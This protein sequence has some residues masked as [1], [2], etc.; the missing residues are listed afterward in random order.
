MLPLLTLEVILYKMKNLR[1]YNVSIPINF[2]Q[3]RLIN[4]CAR[5]N[6]AKITESQKPVVFFYV[7]ELTFL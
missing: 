2:Y 7:E 1:L 4:E 3:N 6:L 5:N